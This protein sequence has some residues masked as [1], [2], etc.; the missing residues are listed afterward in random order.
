MR[1]ISFVP[2]RNVLQAHQA[3][4]SDD[5]SH[6]TNSFRD[7][8]I[9]FV[10]HC[11]RS[12][13]SLCESFLS[14]THLC[15]LPMPDVEGKLIERRSYDCQGAEVL[16]VTIA[17][18]DLCRDRCYFESQTFTNAFFDDWIQMSETA[19]RATD[20]A[21][22]NRF[23]RAHQALAIAKHFAVPKRES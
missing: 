6:T 22:G 19:D 4:G 9:A 12:L 2:E 5:A 10:G 16:S 20:L 8:R 7:D 1:N 21:N 23:A 3:V 17:L 11:A 15:A 13:L 18:N 14:F